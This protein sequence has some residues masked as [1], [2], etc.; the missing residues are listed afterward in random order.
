MKKQ[1]VTTPRCHLCSNPLAPGYDRVLDPQTR[2]IFE[3]RQCKTCE[4]GHTLPQPA[5]LSPYYGPTYHGGRHSLTGSYCAA[6]RVR[7]VNSLTKASIK[8]QRLLDV[9]CGDGTFLLAAE[10]KG[11]KVVGTEMN[12]QIATEAGLEV[13]ESLD[14]LPDTYR[15]DCIT[16][17]HSLEHIRDPQSLIN[18]LATLL[19]PSGVL[20][21]AVPDAG[22][23]QATA[24]KSNWFHL[25]VPRHLYHFTDRSLTRLL[26][27]A[28]LEINRRWHQEFEYDLFGWSQSALNSVM[29]EPNMFFNCLTRK[30]VKIGK[31]LLV[32]NFFIGATL[33]AL[34]LPA[35]MVGTLTKRGGTLIAAAQLTTK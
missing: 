34:A 1:K 13:F 9:G 17:W 18:K 23:L 19:T 24:F 31:A 32:A 14:E 6:R 29:P 10:R 21:I 35:V 7:I 33:S 4:L 8:G 16:M 2:E 25:D 12:P 11:W 28:G 27:N 15:F 26:S 20:L 3:I 22:G 30:P 5:D